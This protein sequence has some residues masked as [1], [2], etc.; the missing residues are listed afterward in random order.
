MN[1]PNS[2]SPNYKLK[3][4]TKENYYLAFSVYN[5]ICDYNQHVRELEFSL[6][7]ILGTNAA[8]DRVCDSMYDPPSHD[9]K[10]IFDEILLNSGVAVDWTGKVIEEESDQIKVE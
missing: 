7:R 6:K 5:T 10:G 8:S 4:L 3:T 1:A 9:R 2:K